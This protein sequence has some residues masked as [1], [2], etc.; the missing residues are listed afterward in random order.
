MKKERQ[1]EEVA[2]QGSSF[3]WNDAIADT[4]EA[5]REV[6][7][8]EQALE[9]LTKAGVNEEAILRGLF[10]YCG[11]IPLA[12]TGTRGK[13][14][15]VGLHEARLF[16]DRVGALANKLSQLADEFEEIVQGLRRF[17]PAWEIHS[18]LSTDMREY[19]KLMEIHYKG[20]RTGRLA[21]SGRN[22]HL[23]YLVQLIRIA[24]GDE[25][26]NELAELGNAVREDPQGS[27]SPEEL[28]KIVKRFASD[29][30]LA[31]DLTTQAQE[32]V[33]EWK[34]VPSPGHRR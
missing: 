16:N 7:Q 28:A 29:L 6:P 32:E 19:A 1:A 5:I 9:T 14:I 27:K 13:K 17:R 24:T 8:A 23:F 34:L 3:E 10:C 20:F 31:A 26:Y 22:H 11:P 25:H 15:D 2:P 12:S 18:G 4:R 21:I 30:L 33:G